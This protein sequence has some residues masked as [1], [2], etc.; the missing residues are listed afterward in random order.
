[1]SVPQPCL[2]PGKVMRPPNKCPFQNTKG[3]TASKSTVRRTFAPPDAEGAFPVHLQGS[4]TAAFEF[5]TAAAC[6][7]SN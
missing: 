7:S 5:C 3:S 6:S 2:P 4:A 1:M